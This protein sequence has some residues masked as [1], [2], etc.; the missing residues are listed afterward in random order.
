[1]PSTSQKNR[2]IRWRCLCFLVRY[3]IFF[4]FLLCTGTR[5]GFVILKT[6]ALKFPQKPKTPGENFEIPRTLT[7][8]NCPNAFP[9]T[10]PTKYFTFLLLLNLRNKKNL[11]AEKPE[12]KPIFFCTVEKFEPKLMEK[13]LCPSVHRCKFDCTDQLSCRSRVHTAMA[14]SW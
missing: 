7:D 14:S 6:L 4:L 13:K 2:R 9:D 8:K 1:M 12:F 5:F 3:R 11:L 10:V